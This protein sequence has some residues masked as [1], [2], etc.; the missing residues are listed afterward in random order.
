MRLKRVVAVAYE[1]EVGREGRREEGERSC[2]PVSGQMPPFARVAAITEA[3]S[4]V[5]STEHIYETRLSRD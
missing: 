3:D 1:R 4:Q 2:C 5:T